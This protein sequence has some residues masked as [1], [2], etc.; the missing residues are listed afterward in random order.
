[1]DLNSLIKYWVKNSADKLIQNKRSFSLANLAILI[2]AFM[3]VQKKKP[4]KVK[5]IFSNI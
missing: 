5:N 2:T 4:L 3:H 1:M